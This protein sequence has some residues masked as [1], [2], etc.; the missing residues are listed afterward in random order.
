[1]SWV[2]VL[3]SM[4][5]A[6]CLM[7][8]LIYGLIW[9]GQRN[10]WA[11]LLF[12][13][14]ALG[15]AAYA[16]CD[17]IGMHADTPAQLATA[18]RWTHV[19]IWIPFLALAGFVRLYFRAGRVWLLWTICTLRT[20]SL[21]LN[22]LTGENLNY[23]E[24]TSLHHVF[25]LGELVSVPVGVLNPWMLVGQM[26][27][28]GLWIFV[29]DATITVWRRGERRL[30]V[31]L[32]G[33]IL[34][35]ITAGTAQTAMI[36]V[37]HAEWP[38]SASVFYLVIIAAMAYEVGGDALRA[39]RLA[40]ELRVSEERI[41]LAAE[42]ANLGFWVREYAA[43]DIWATDHWRR[44]FGFTKSER[45]H[46]D[47]Y[48]ERLHPDDREMMRQTLAKAPAEGRYHAQ[49]RVSL[50]NGQI[51]WIASQGCVEFGARGQPIRSQGV[52]MD[53]TIGKH[54]DLEIQAHRNEVAHLLRVAS[55]GELSSAL[56][57][58][59]SQPLTAILI[60]AQTALLFLA[61]G[62]FDQKAI[63]EILDDIVAS[64]QRA[65]NIIHR[66]RSLLK[67]DVFQAQSLEINPLIQEVLTLMRYE[68]ISRTVRV[69]T[70]LADGL[71]SVRGDRVQLQQVMI[72]LILNAADAMSYPAINVRTL[73]V[74]SKR[75]EGGAV[76][77]SVADT[78]V[79]I[80]SGH[81]ETIFEPYHTTKTQGL[82][83]GLSLSRS[84]VS[85]HFGHLWAENQ[86]ES[87]AIFHFTIPEWNEP[88][89]P[90]R[91]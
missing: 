61:G 43:D 89:W 10:G 33:S 24:I 64:D 51:R 54:A 67:K 48:L 63:R 34:V 77:I 86:A 30:A 78:G 25:Y 1:M 12:A 3:Y 26:S 79:G 40:G 11:N 13:V 69:V 29:L 22:F 16:G 56:A 27:L 31:S 35:F 37:G 73:T 74:G 85:A 81:E 65:G 72:N 52:S 41:T 23:R 46:F 90:D 20:L 59:L 18:I 57:H 76:Q 53:I 47:Q 60:D 39:V 19:A 8:A 80:L 75:A 71:P 14:A 42:A 50:P 15:T 82:G 45:L 9:W 6:A 5:A 88:T 28:L 87:G 68:L 83:L 62:D 58:E 21:F 84:I 17:L 36:V 91:K 66:L 70:E 32:G 55:I 7:M 49:Y 44:L 38:F 2:I 4:V